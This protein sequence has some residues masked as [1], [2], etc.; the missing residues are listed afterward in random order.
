[1]ADWPCPAFL[2]PYHSPVT[3]TILP[4]AWYTPD[5][6][7]CKLY[8]SHALPYSTHPVF[9]PTVCTLL[10]LT[11]RPPLRWRQAVPSGKQPSLSFPE[12]PYA[13]SSP[14]NFSHCSH[15]HLQ[16]SWVMLTIYPIS[17][18]KKLVLEFTTAPPGPNSRPAHRRSSAS[19]CPG[20]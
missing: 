7:P 5:P 4:S 13:F 14:P 20:S 8:T 16:L 6:S 3:L 10:I 18:E 2:W 11:H 12:G 17:Q 19:V 9:P 15:S 1:M